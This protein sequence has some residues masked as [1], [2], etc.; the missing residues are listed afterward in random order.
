MKC[1]TPLAL[2]ALALAGVLTAATPAPAAAQRT[3]VCESYRDRFNHCSVDT[4]GG[5]RLIRRLS[6]AACI[7]GRS[8][9][10]DR[11]GIW[12][13]RGCRA[14]FVV[15]R[16]S[17]ERGDWD[18]DRDRDWDRDRGR[19]DWNRSDRSGRVQAER[20][21]HRAVRDLVRGARSG[22]IDVDYVSGDRRGNRVVRWRTDRASGVCRVDRYDRVV[23]FTRT[24]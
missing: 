6:D 8:W 12:V 22:R 17:R 10:T 1:K 20:V 15:G 18:R 7:S 21:C 4:R 2:S 19:G 3:I 11:R 16:S 14:E 9:G 5:V 13:S 24:S 23:S